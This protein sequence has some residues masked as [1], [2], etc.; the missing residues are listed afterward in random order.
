MANLVERHPDDDLDLDDW[1]DVR[2]RVVQPVVHGLFADHE[3]SSFEVYSQPASLPPWD[4]W[5]TDL[6]VPRDVWCRVTF[7]NAEQAQV[8]LGYQGHCDPNA[9][10][11]RLA[12]QLEDEFSES[13][14]GWGQERVA[15][16]KVLPASDPTGP[17]R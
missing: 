17:R 7:F 1:A 6:P 8:W 2:H 16:Y 14:W 5:P 13:R 3:V 9:V 10:A 12:E 11:S 15:T 4:H